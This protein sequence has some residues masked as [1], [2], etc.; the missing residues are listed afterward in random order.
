MTTPPTKETAMSDQLTLFPESDA[1]SLPR[2]P[3]PIPQPGSTP[4][5]DEIPVPVPADQ[6]SLFSLEGLQ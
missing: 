6:P 3:W 5:A 2:K 1:I 4:A